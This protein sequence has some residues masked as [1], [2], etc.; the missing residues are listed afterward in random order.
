MVKTFTVVQKMP[1]FLLIYN[2]ISFIYM[3]LIGF[4][5]K[6]KKVKIFRLQIQTESMSGIEIIMIF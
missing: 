5:F 1:R 3:H 6:K 2:K 4:M